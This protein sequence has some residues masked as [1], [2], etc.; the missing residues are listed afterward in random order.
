MAD[1]DKEFEMI[2]K[3]LELLHPKDF[4]MLEN[5]SEAAIESMSIF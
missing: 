4:S 2:I 1:I 3:V 5:T